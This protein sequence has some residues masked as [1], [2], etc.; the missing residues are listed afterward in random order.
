LDFIGD[1]SVLGKPAGSDLR[2]GNVTLPAIY[3][4][5]TAESRERNLLLAFLQSKGR[6]VSLSTVVDIV[7]HS[8]GID[9]SLKLAD[10]YLQKALTVLRRLPSCGARDSLE[11]IARFVGSR[12]Y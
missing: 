11:R 10:R 8:G 1:E 4:L 12:S 6:D 9:F 3:A 2:Q 5:R 7:R